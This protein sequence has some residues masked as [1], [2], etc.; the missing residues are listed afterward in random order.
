MTAPLDPV[1]PAI[2]LQ[3]VTQLAA[4]HANLTT[5]VRRLLETSTARCGDRGSVDVHIH[6][7]ELATLRSLT[8]AP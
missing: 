1:D 5:L 7:E 2:V 8:G 6:A 4:D 3:R